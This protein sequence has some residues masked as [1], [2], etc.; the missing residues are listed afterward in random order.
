M[1]AFATRMT[2]TQISNWFANAR[3]RMKQQ[4]DKGNTSDGALSDFSDD[5][6]K[7]NSPVYDSL[8]TAGL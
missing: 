6:N 7:S 2:M 3:R 8:H 1:L 5:D 4:K